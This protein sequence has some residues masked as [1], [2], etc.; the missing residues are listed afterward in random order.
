[1]IEALQGVPAIGS[2]SFAQPL[3]L[4]TLAAAPLGWMFARVEVRRRRAADLRYGGPV[5]LHPARRPA[6]ARFREMVLLLALVTLAL[7]AARPT[8]GRDDVPLVRRGIDLVIALDVSR[9]MTANDVAPTR[10]VAASAG[11]ARLLRALPGDRAG[12]VIFAGTA[13]AR[14]PLTHDLATL[15]QLIAQAQGEAGLLDPGTDLA[16]AIETAL[17]SLDVEDRGATQVI[18]AVS[19]GEHVGDG[20]LDLALRRARDA[21]VRVYAVAAGTETGGAMTPVRGRSAVERA[22]LDRSTLDRIAEATGASVRDLGSV[23]GLAVEFS[24][25]RQTTFEGANEE[26]HADRFPWFIGT[27][28]ALLVFHSLTTET[29]AR[30]GAVEVARS[31]RTHLLPLTAAVALLLDAC[32]GTA[33]WQQV[34]AGNR[35]YDGARYEEALAAYE[36]TA[37]LASPGDQVAI[38]YNRGNTL[39]R[40]RRYEEATTASARAVEDA[41]TAGLRNRARYALGNHAFRR[42]DLDLARDAYRAVLLSDPGDEDAR[43]NLELVLLQQQARARAPGQPQAGGTPP[44]GATP[45]AGQPGQTGQPGGP[46]QPGTPGTGQG[47][48]G[49]AG[50][51][52]G[53]GAP[54]TE[55]EAQ[56]A[57]ARLLAELGDNATLDEALAV[58]DRLRA[59]DTFGRLHDG[60]RTGTLPDR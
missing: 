55:A 44:P 34:D 53:D 28:L 1:M 43:H 47:Q 31:A 25:L 18:V 41:P 30:T 58:L 29:R 48:P 51:A 27:A 13:L 46:T 50:A 45:G 36:R 60:R 39:H 7:A 8:W 10:A 11:L 54:L 33:A 26:V 42:G 3:A 16:L 56:T 12:L 9:S 21:G 17:R 49:S 19:D 4:L 24:R 22:S 59:L 15:Q 35:A 5:G 40:L 2:L 57:L 6:R 32:S 20:D 38:V 37:P 52:A 23:T 14:A